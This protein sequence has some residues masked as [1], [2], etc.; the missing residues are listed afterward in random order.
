M[1][2]PTKLSRRRVFWC[3][4][5]VAV[6]FLFVLGKLVFIQIIQA[7]KY[8]SEAL[9]QWM[10]NTAVSAKRGKIMDINGTV[11]AESATAYKVLI[12]PNQISKDDWERVSQELANIEELNLSYEYI[13]KRV[14]NTLTEKPLNEI[15]LARQLEREVA[16]K[17]TALQL[18][19]E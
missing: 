18:G 14:S 13:Y 2:K 19:P 6:A 7:D 3:S 12:W 8:Q 16:D 5:F 17:I 9:S 10:R 15:V 11:L 4:L 1:G